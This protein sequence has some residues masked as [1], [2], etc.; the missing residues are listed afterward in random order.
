MARL[1]KLAQWSGL[2]TYGLF[3]WGFLS[4]EDLELSSSYED[5]TSPNEVSWNFIYES[6]WSR[7]STKAWGF[8]FT[9]FS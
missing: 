7:L 2:P 8:V 6:V 9:V 3:T 5:E 1:A 4:T